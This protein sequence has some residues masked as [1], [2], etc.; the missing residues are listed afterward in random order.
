MKNIVLFGCFAL[1]LMSFSIFKKQASHKTICK[2]KIIDTVFVCLPCGYGCDNL[3]YKESGF[4]AQCNMPL[5]NKATIFFKNIEPA[6]ICSFIKK[7]GKQKVVLLDVRT[8]EEFTGNAPDKFGRLDGA[9]NIPVQELASRIKELNQYKNKDILVYCS[10][11]HRSPRAS[12]LLTQNGFN[13]VT[14]MLYGM[15]EWNNKVKEDVCNKKL[16]VKQ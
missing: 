11:S 4:C 16:F 12:Y 1:L 3:V 14:N 10:H 15:S 6:E 8:N 7:R 5:V 2:E 9:I 13:K